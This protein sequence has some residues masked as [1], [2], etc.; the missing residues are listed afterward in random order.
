MTSKIRQLI[1]ALAVLVFLV[2][3]SAAKADTFQVTLSGGLTGVLDL[4]AVSNGGGSYLV[5]ALTGTESIGGH[6]LTVS[7]LI[8]PTSAGVHWFPP[9]TGDGFTYDNLIFP[10][11]TPIFDNG[12]LLFT[13]L[14]AGSAP[15]YE[16][17]YSVLNLGYL[18]SAY[19]GTGVFPNDFTYIPVNVSVSNI[20]N[21]VVATPEPSSLVL[22]LA[23]MAIVGA[24]LLKKS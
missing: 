15:V 2:G 20:S 21:L 1:L 17:L 3:A 9:P 22:V 10:G 23:G 13:V 12:G 11:S 5:T 6:T 18:Q 14:G 19:L 16:N 4:T 8:A 24:F 7:Q